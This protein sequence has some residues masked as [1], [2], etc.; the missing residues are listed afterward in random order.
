MKINE[1]NNRIKEF[2]QNIR[3]LQEIKREYIN[4]GINGRY[5]TTLDEGIDCIDQRLE[6]YKNTD[7]IMT[8]VQ[9]GK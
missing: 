7:W 2:E 3:T 1:I 6:H 5:I 9:W 8:T 4:K